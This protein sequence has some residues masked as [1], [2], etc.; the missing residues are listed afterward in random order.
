ML[1]QGVQVSLAKDGSATAVLATYYG[2]VCV[3]T[4][5]LIAGFDKCGG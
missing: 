1:Q 2:F 5:S 3:L 4:V